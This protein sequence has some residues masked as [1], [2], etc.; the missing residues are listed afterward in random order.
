MKYNKSELIAMAA[1]AAAVET[2]E[3]TGKNHSIHTDTVR[4]IGNGLFDNSEIE[5]LPY[6]ENRKVDVDVELMTRETYETT[7]LANSSS[8]WDDMFTDNDKILVII[9]I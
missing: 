2:Y 3:Y 5:E 4:Y 8:S 9:L 7:I 1:Q 6:D